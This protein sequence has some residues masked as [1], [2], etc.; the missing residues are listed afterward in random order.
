MIYGT[1]CTLSCFWDRHLWKWFLFDLKVVLGFIVL[2]WWLDRLG[3]NF[4]AFGFI[5]KLVMLDEM[6][7]LCWYIRF[8][9]NCETVYTCYIIGIGLYGND[10]HSRCVIICPR[11]GPCDIIYINCIIDTPTWWFGWWRGCNPPTAIGGPNRPAFRG[12]MKDPVLF[13][14]FRWHIDPWLDAHREWECHHTDP[15]GQR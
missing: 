10:I 13:I 4:Y 15:V 11:Q 9:M 2:N 5:T 8:E 6:L 3:R 14:H 7:M 1:L 12:F